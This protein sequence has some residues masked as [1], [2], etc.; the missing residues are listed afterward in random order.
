MP[1]LNTSPAKPRPKN[2]VGSAW[3]LEFAAQSRYL[4]LNR[5]VGFHPPAGPPL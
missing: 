3:P 4:R 5:T 1:R 2:A